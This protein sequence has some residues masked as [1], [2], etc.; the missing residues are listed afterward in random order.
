MSIVSFASY[1]RTERGGGAAFRVETA[2]MQLLNDDVTPQSEPRSFLGEV[3]FKKGQSSLLGKF[4][5][6]GKVIR[7]KVLNSDT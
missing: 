3:P 5:F 4:L 6:K 1:F 2:L 7:C